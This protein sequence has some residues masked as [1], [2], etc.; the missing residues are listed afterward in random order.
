ML[1]CVIYGAPIQCYESLSA[2][3]VLLLESRQAPGRCKAGART[4]TSASAPAHTRSANGAVKSSL[5]HHHTSAATCRSRWIK[6]VELPSV[7]STV[8][9]NAMPVSTHERPPSAE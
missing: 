8:R 6:V 4:H 5:P 1:G 2:Q 7:K 9:L 3:V